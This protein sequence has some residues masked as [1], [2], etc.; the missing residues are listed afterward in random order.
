[1]SNGGRRMSAT[2]E[3]QK[4]IAAGACQRSQHGEQACTMTGRRR[5]PRATATTRMISSSQS[6]MSGAVLVL[7]G[8]GSRSPV[9]GVGDAGWAHG[10]TLGGAG[11]GLARLLGAGPGLGDPGRQHELLT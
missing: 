3:R 5:L 4:T 9:P 10:G 1:M 6:G 7:V 2:P 8:A 11:L